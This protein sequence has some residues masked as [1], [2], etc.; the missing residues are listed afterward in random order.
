MHIHKRGI[1]MT[2]NN[3]SHN[4]LIDKIKNALTEKMERPDFD[5]NNWEYISENNLRE[6]MDSLYISSRLNTL[7]KYEYSCGGYG[8]SSCR[9]CKERKKGGEK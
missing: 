4:E 8:G 3:E 2:D 7:C 5:N 9:N 1:K 6:V